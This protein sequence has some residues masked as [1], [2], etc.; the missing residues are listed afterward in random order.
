[1]TILLKMGMFHCYVSLPEGGNQMV[2]YGTSINDTL[3]RANLNC[4]SSTDPGVVIAMG[5]D[6]CLHGNMHAA[7]FIGGIYSNE[8]TATTRWAPTRYK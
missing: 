2:W 6:G 8:P 5:G 7:V 1:M 4:C 3:L